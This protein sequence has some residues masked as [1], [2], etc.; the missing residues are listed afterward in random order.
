MTKILTDI[1]IGARL[2]QLRKMAGMTQ[3]RLSELMGVSSHQV[4]KYERGS[5]K[6]STYRLQQV[7]Q[8][9]SVS[10]Q[11]LFTAS[12]DVPSNEQE[13]LLLSAFRSIED[14]EVQSSIVKVVCSTSK[15]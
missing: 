11:A 9:L 4:Q 10:V 12:D 15:K 5:D 1:E 8:I 7:S 6:L 2:K 14:K 13:K 3:E